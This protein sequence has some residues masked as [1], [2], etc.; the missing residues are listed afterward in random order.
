MVTTVPFTRILS[1]LNHQLIH[2][3]YSFSA[4]DF[5]L[6]R[7]Y[8]FCLQPEAWKVPSRIQSCCMGIADGNWWSINSQKCF[9]SMEDG[10]VDTTVISSQ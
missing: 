1:K 7:L 3:Y 8:L 5:I 9:I 4:H 10:G 2:Y 6:Y